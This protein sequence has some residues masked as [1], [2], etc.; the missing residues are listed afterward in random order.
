MN[1]NPFVGRE[2]ELKELESVF[3]EVLNYN[4]TF[5]LIRGEVGVGKTRLVEE[6]I[7]SVES[8]RVWVLKG[9]LTHNDMRPYSPFLQMIEDQLEK[10]EYHSQRL[11]KFIE[12]DAFPS[13]AHFLPKLRD[14]YPIEIPSAKSQY[15]DSR[16]LFNSIEKFF[17]NLSKLKPLVLVLDDIIWMDDDSIELFKFIVSHIVN[18]SIFILCTS[19]PW[20]KNSA[21]QTTIGEFTEYRT[22]R[23]HD[24]ENITELDTENL[25]TTQFGEKISS[26]FIS[27]LY[28]ITKGNPLFISEVLNVLLRRNILT[29]QQDEEKWKVKDDFKNFPLSPTIDSIINLHLRNLTPEALSILQTGSVLGEEFKLTMLRKLNHRTSKENFFKAFHLLKVQKVLEE[30]DGDILKFSHP[31]IREVIYRELKESKRRKLH[32]KISSFLKKRSEA[33]IEEIIHHLTFDL[34]TEEETPELCRYL[35]K[36]GKAILQRYDEHLGWNCMT[37]ANNIVKKFPKQLKKEGLKSEAELLRLRWVLGKNPTSFEETEELI[38]RLK[39]ANL[40]KEAVMLYRLLFYRAIV[41]FDIDSAKNFLES[42]LSISKVSEENYWVLR[43]ESCLIKRREG[44]FREAEEEAQKLIEEI[45]PDIASGALWKVLHNLGAIAHVRGDLKKA[46]EL[47]LKAIDV[48][49]KY[50]LTQYRADSYINLGYIEMEMGQLDSAL[51]K[52]TEV[53]EDAERTKR[54][55]KLA[56][57]WIVLGR[58]LLAKGELKTSLGY[59]NDSFRKAKEIGFKRAMVAAR[60]NR[61]KVFLEMNK[62]NDALEEINSIS[63]KELQKNMLCDFHLLKSRIWLKKGKQE[64]SKQ[65]NEKSLKLAEKLNLSIY[66]AS[67]LAQKGMI[68]LKIHKESEALILLEKVKQTLLQKGALSF[69]SSIL[70]RFGLALGGNKGEDIFIEGLK[71]LFEMNALPRVDY[72]LRE[73]KRREFEKAHTIAHKKLNKFISKEDRIEIYTFGGLSVRRPKEL[74]PIS[75]NEWQSRKARELF[76]L[77]LILSTTS[78]TTREILASYLW[79]DANTSKSQANFRVT[80]ARLN[81]TLGYDC[82]RQEA[83][84]L[85]LD[86]RNL[87]VDFV[88]F[89]DFF[90][91][92]YSLQQKG[93]LHLAEKKAQEAVLLYN[94]DFLPELYNFPIDQKQMELKE[95]VS[96]L[97]Y[98]LAMRSR[99]RFEWQEAIS[100]AHNLITLDP[101][102][103]EGAHR[104]IMEGLWSQGD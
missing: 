75:Q 76:G 51:V 78:G 95:K 63:A 55:Q 88:Q 19:R 31:L 59:F 50:N 22:I 83:Q 57:T 74:R 94:G 93:K 7:K 56:A 82:I 29:Y 3:D 81:R 62:I 84:F 58:C 102:G 44:K 61:V 21:F 27:W 52:I 49:E 41:E 2:K 26:Q 33:R 90:K 45:D 24:L 46:H 9:K 14:Y 69:L 97:L 80:L 73:M 98:W 12:P 20:M 54:A 25:I 39:T 70:I 13:L 99:E 77:I 87:W 104:I 68:L 64:L 23:I 86:H 47:M 89:E 34:T 11:V 4:G 18:K 30:K 60:F 66:I 6:F 40:R 91:E 10:I 1:I 35:L 15:S 92:W 38:E 8:Q 72:L 85:F 67:A 48:S 79:P 65:E 103:S 37:I 42:G 101:I 16:Q 100:L 32:R 36:T 96:R 71:I 53:V 17:S 28:S 43:V 5:V